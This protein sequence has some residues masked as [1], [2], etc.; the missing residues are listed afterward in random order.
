[1]EQVVFLDESGFNMSMTRSYARAYSTLR[2]I[3][4]V[5]RNHGINYT[6]I[7][8]LQL[9]G[10]VGELIID[11][12]V[13]GMVF[14]HYIRDILC[15][16]LTEG[17]TVVMDNLSSHHRESIRGFIE[18]KGCNLLYLPSYSPD[19]NPIEMMFSKVKALVRGWG[20]RSGEELIQAVWDA[21]AAVSR[22]DI[23][24]WFRC[25]HPGMVL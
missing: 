1:M 25:V 15:P 14:E 8:G 21:L 16:Q 20:K 18:G 17:Q 24:G 2:A 23:L 12:S 9:S 6:L 3:G 19:F 4:T 5:P 10:P 13:N 11:G 22:G 7:C